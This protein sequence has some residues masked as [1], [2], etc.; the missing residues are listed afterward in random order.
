M[1]ILHGFFRRVMEKDAVGIS[2]L[3]SP[4]ATFDDFCISGMFNH[5]THLI[6]REAID[7]YFAN[8]FIF[9]TYFCTDFEERDS[10]NGTMDVTI[11]GK[12]VQADVAIKELDHEG[13]IKSMIVKPIVA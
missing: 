5:E 12:P 7:M 8:R 4:E 3:F 13:K 11:V 10:L 1:N 2:N 6:G 9:R